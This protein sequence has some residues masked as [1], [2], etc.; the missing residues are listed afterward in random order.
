MAMP[1]KNAESVSR[2]LTWSEIDAMSE[3]ELRAA[4]LAD[5]CDPDALIATVRKIGREARSKFKSRVERREW[6]IFGTMAAFPTYDQ[7]VAAGAPAWGDCAEP[8]SSTLSLVDILSA[9]SPDN[10]FWAKVEGW[11]MRDE[12]I[13]HG[14]YLLVK[15]KA[16]AKDGDVVL[17]HLPGEGH[18]VKKLRITSAGVV[19][20]SANPDFADIVV[21]DPS[22]LRIQGVV[23][24]RA[25]TL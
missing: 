17:A 20:A 19:L 21:K 23:V 4:H 16:D 11:S 9:S 24:G 1:K 15:A 13:K 6:F 7:A 5:G 25:G 18:V 3:D 14:D 8:A 10:T 22:S 2:V 12:G